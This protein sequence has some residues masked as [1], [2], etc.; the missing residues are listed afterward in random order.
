MKINKEKL[1][2]KYLFDL[3]K[4]S[5]LYP[6]EEDVL[7]EYI[8]LLNEKG[9]INKFTTADLRRWRVKL[10]K[11]YET[12]PEIM[13]VFIEQGYFKE[14]NRYKKTNTLLIEYETI[15]HPWL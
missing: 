3:Y 10:P 9:K 12:I 11:E 1:K 7:Y 4:I 13:N 15:K 5:P 14:L 8:C 2:I 6:T